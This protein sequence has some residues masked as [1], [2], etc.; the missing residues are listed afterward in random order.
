MA[1]LQTWGPDLAVSPAWARGERI[2]RVRHARGLGSRGDG[3]EWSPH[4]PSSPR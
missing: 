2:Q 4:L 1:S 3:S